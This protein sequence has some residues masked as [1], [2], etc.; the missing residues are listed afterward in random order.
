MY[1]EWPADVHCGF[2]TAYIRLDDASPGDMF[3]AGVEFSR[4]GQELMNKFRGRLRG[5]LNTAYTFSVHDYLK[6]ARRVCGYAVRLYGETGYPVQML[7]PYLT[8]G[9]PL[10]TLVVDWDYLIAGR[11]G[12]PLD[13]SGPTT[14]GM[15]SS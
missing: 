13:T 14:R 7:Y 6:V 2:L 8:A 11:L 1:V 9:N 12:A 15:V 5:F 3:T 4:V 10:Y